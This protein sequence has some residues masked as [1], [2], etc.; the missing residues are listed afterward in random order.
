MKERLYDDLTDDYEEGIDPGAINL[1]MTVVLLCAW[2]DND[3]GFVVMHGWELYVSIQ[4]SS[5]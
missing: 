4:F 5:M 1:Q 2:V 3:T